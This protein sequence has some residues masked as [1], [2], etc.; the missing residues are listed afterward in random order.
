MNVSNQARALPAPHSFPAP[1]SLFAQAV[2]R[3]RRVRESLAARYKLAR[4]LEELHQFNDRELS[5]LG[6]S[7]CDLPAIAKGEFRRD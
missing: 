5:D 3:L 2:I 6:L 4:D 1:R 7:R